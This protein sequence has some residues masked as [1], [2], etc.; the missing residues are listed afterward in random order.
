MVGARSGRAL[1]TWDRK[2]DMFYVVYLHFVLFLAFGMF[3]SSLSSGT[4]QSRAMLNVLLSYCTAIDFVPLYPAVTPS[5]ART[6]YDY[7]RLKYND[8]LYAKDP[9][10]FRL[11]AIVEAVFTVPVCVWS[12]RGLI[13]GT[14]LPII[15]ILGSLHIFRR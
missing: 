10:F 6:F 11:Y 15:Y 7:F 4:A 1:S 9:P 8:P 3:S 13:Q 5:W 14:L 12:I 2:V